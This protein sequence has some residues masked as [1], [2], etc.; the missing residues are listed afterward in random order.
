M[1]NNDDNIID[2]IDTKINLEKLYSYMKEVLSDREIQILTLR[3][4]LKG[5]KPLTQREISSKRG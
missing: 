2:E 4:G 1:D 3:F 5:H